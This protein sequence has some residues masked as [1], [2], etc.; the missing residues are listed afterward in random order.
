MRNVKICL[1]LEQQLL[2]RVLSMEQ[3]SLEESLNQLL[4][5]VTANTKALKE[6]DSQLLDRLSRSSGNLLDDMELIEVLANTKAK[7]KEVEKKLKDAQEKKTEVLAFSF[8]LM[9][10]LLSPLPDP[11][12]T[13]LIWCASATAIV[14]QSQPKGP[15]Y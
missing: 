3:R 14:Q 15:L 7:A 12:A 11:Y 1:G 13:D 8:T 5:S 9:W 10:F 2:G 4:E 6:L